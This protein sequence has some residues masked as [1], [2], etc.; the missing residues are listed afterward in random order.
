M[1]YKMEHI[2]QLLRRFMDGETSEQEEKILEEYFSHDDDIPEEWATYRE[3]FASFSTDAYD[4][5]EEEKQSFL[6]EPKKAKVRM[7]WLW[8][9]AACIAALIL[10]LLPPPREKNEPVAKVDDSV[11]QKTKVEKHDKTKAILQSAQEENQED[12]TITEKLIAAETAMTPDREHIA[13]DSL[14]TIYSCSQPSEDD[15][16]SVT[17]ASTA[18]QDPN[19]VVEFVSKLAATFEAE[20][21]WLDCMKWSDKSPFT[22][23]YVFKEDVDVK[24]RLLQVACW[25]DNALPGYHLMLNSQQLLFELQDVSKRKQYLWLVEK[26]GDR[27]LLVASQANIGARIIPPCYNDFKRKIKDNYSL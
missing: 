8:L 21:V 15:G 1:K 5:S 7:S 24:G 14:Q 25:Y 23:V 18:S 6:K 26:V 13:Q 22:M 17:Q 4:F 27:T 19:L 10:V 11:I 12:Q 20:K 3:M 2:E 9:V 16:N